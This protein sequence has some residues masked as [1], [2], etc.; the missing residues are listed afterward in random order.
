[1]Q[2]YARLPD[3][4][5]WRIRHYIAT[6]QVPPPRNSTQRVSRFANA[7]F[8]LG[9]AIEGAVERGG[10]LDVRTS[11]GPIELDFLIFATGFKV[12]W[13]QRPMLQRIAP[14]I[15]VWKDRY[16]PPA[17]SEDDELAESPDLGPAFE[18]QPREG[19]DCPGLE[20][21]HCLSYPATLSLGVI[22]GDIPAISEGALQLADRLAGLLYAEDIEQHFARMQ[23]FDE[24]EILGDEWVAEPLPPPATR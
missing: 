8:H 12:D 3:D 13:R 21:V 4:W 15:R 20:R 9:V 14:A 6:Q 16:A 10:G 23:A 24:P 5:K 17:G 2:G 19:A 1:V 18:F 7:H 11:A 22:T